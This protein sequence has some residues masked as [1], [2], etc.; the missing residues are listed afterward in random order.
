L[1]DKLPADVARLLA[2]AD[3][4]ECDEAWGAFVRAYT[5]L[6]LRVARSLGGGQDAVMDRYAFVLE[7]LRQEGCRRLRAYERPGAGAFGLW[8]VVVARR[9]CLDHYRQR[10]GR[11]RAPDGREDQPLDPRKAR[12]RLADLI[13]D[14]VDVAGVP[15]P[16]TGSPDQVLARS[17]RSRAVAAA[18]EGLPPSD[19]LLLRLRF[20]E[21]LPAREIAALMTFPTVFHVYRRLDAVLRT[22]R[23]VLEQA[24]VEDAEP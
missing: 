18:L 23:A 20:V 1:P 14:Q 10:Y 24:G 7:Q 15:A 19:R 4:R 17:E 3:P 22:L 6:L 21:E 13:G 8:L 12:R 9:L 5:D 16:D 11:A 2:A